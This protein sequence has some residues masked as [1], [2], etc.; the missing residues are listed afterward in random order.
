MDKRILT[1]EEL[2]QLRKF[3]ISRSQRFAE[4]SVLLEIMDHFACKT[5]EVL[6][7]EPSLSLEQAMKKAHHSF[8]IKG[9]API[10]EACEQHIYQRYKKLCQGIR[11]NI[12]LS[13]HSLGLAATG[14]LFA[15]LYS[16]AHHQHFL[17]DNG[18]GVVIILEL[19]YAAGVGMLMQ[20]RKT[21]RK[22]HQLVY[23]KAYEA[24]QYIFA[25]LWLGFLLIPVQDMLPPFLM[26]G[27]VGF[28]ASFFMFQLLSLHRLIIKV[29]ADV[30]ATEQRL[31]PVS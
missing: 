20:R 27:L 28:L 25:W 24:T 22:K 13:W 23:A 21:T 3:I 31:Q 11:I 5:E 30:A 7:E 26:S 12:L 16:L 15:R 6:T 8:G 14:I 9:F 29:N 18:L 1:R 19:L 10:A 4:P 17:T 2:L